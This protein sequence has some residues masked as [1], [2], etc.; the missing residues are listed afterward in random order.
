MWYPAGLFAMIIVVARTKVAK[1]AVW[2]LSS[3]S[4][5]LPELLLLV[6]LAW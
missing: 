3:G 2:V 5:A 6:T 1:V 4:F